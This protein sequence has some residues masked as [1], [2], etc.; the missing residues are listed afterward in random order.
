[1]SESLL[2][3]P[4]PGVSQGVGGHTPLCDDL[5]YPANPLLLLVASVSRV[6]M[7]VGGPGLGVWFHVSLFQLRLVNQHQG[8]GEALA[9]QNCF[10]AV[11]SEQTRPAMCWLPTGPSSLAR[12]GKRS[13]ASMAWAS[14][15]F[16]LRVVCF[17]KGW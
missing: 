8:L 6:Q 10:M 1:M 3:F 13:L 7:R 5:L 9:Q 11:C 4:T 17:W 15:C 16:V 14:C 2:G 12:L